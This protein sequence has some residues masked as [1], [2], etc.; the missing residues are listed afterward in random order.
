MAAKEASTRHV[1]LVSCA[2]VKFIAK[3]TAESPR[4][5]GHSTLRKQSRVPLSVFTHKAPHSLPF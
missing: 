2:V 1:S 5:L 4:F 3:D